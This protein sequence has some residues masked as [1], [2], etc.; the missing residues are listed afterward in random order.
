[1]GLFDWSTDANS[2]TGIDSVNIAENCPPGG[3]NNAIRAV[4]AN[5]RTAFSS[6]LAGFFNGTDALP[7]TNGGTG[8]KTRA[9]ARTT[10]R[11]ATRTAEA[12]LNV[13][14]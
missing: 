10:R 2:N 7:V 5:V 1:M 3:I 12:S 14:G 11:P 13:V 9:A 6:G 4:M 8:G